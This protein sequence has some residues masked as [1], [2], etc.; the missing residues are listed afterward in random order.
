[1]GLAESDPQAAK[2]L[3]AFREVLSASGWKDGQNLQID[4]RA[5]TDLEALRSRAS[6]L[7]SLGPQ[8]VL[9]YPT[10]ATNAVHQATRT[11]PIVF[12]AVSDP[13]GTGFVDSFSHRG[14]NVTGF[15]NFEP[16]MG[17]K[18]VELMHEIAPSVQR[19]AMLFNPATANGGA[20]KDPVCGGSSA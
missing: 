3:V 14:R 17:S 18:W 8:L 1:M 11:L 19:V 2:F 9:T 10:P 7:I 15:T 16:T 4:F 20:V 6:E 13:I 5:A 12:V